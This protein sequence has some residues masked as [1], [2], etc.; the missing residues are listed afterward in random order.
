LLNRQ[1]GIEFDPSVPN[2]KE[3]AAECEIRQCH[4][5]EGARDSDAD[6]KMFYKQMVLS[7]QLGGLYTVNKVG[8]IQLVRWV[9]YS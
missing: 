3:E 6:R 1:D 9:I 4:G 8:Y 7:M 5:G 2:N